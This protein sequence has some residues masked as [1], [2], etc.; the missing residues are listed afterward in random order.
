M[1]ALALA[2]RAERLAAWRVAAGARRPCLLSRRVTVPAA[3][4]EVAARH[5]EQLVVARSAVAVRQLDVLRVIETH[6][7]Q[8]ARERETCRHGLPRA[9]GPGQQRD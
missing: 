5:L 7:T 3:E 8:G 2:L 6:R 4:A 1:T 9:L